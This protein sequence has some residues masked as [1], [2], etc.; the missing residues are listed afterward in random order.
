MENAERKNIF[1]STAFAVCLAM[2]ATIAALY[3]YNIVQWGNY[4]NFGYGFRSATGIHVVGIVNENGKQAG[5]QVGDNLIEVNGKTYTT[6]EE[7][8]GHMRRELGEENTYLL[9]RDGRRFAVTIKN[10]PTGLKQSFSKSGLSYLLGLC[11]VL[12]GFLV[13]L[14]K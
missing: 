6:I 1:S 10:L 11:Y 5:M 12:I 2:V 9:E 14:M 3:F 13:F 7:F 8:R 4:P